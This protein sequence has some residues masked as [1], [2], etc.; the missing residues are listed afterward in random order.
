M[1]VF[2]V[3]QEWLKVKEKHK[4]SSS[5]HS[6]LRAS[7]SSAKWPLICTGSFVWIGSGR[8]QNTCN[9]TTNFILK[10]INGWKLTVMRLLLSAQSHRQQLIELIE[11]NTCREPL[12][13]G[14]IDAEKFL[15]TILTCRSKLS[16]PFWAGLMASCFLEFLY[17]ADKQHHLVAVDL[18]LLTYE[19]TVQSVGRAEDARIQSSEQPA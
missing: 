5:L 9:K 2:W 18:V 19:L 10:S 16:V 8:K 12:M 15:M 14:Q 7:W 6:P 4:P 17:W 13:S 1:T 3:T 11:F